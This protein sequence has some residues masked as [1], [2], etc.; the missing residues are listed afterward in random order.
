MNH[1][2]EIEIENMEKQK[3]WNKKKKSVENY[4]KNKERKK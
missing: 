3:R 2:K 1:L 4:K